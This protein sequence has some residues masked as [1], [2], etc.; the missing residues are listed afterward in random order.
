M[1]G[2]AGCIAGRAAEMQHLRACQEKYYI[3]PF[4]EP[5]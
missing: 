5:D 3:S 1:L 4:L 2:G